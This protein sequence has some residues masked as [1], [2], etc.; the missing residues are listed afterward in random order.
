MAN[1]AP[2]PTDKHVGSRVRTRRMMLGMSQ[3]KLA[4][5]LGISFQQVQKYEN[6]TSRIGAGRL[7]H[8][9]QIL[10]V[11]AAFFFEALPAPRSKGA[12]SAAYV[13]EFLA[14]SDGIALMSAFTR[15][16]DKQLRRSIVK[17]VV[18]IVR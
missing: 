7:Q 3:K 13:S 17:L 9:A 1:K 11:P 4:D 16:G 8:I 10:R 18:T 2:N 14:T 5:A 12:P 15:I 6:G